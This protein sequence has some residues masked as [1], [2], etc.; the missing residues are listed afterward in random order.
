MVA[1]EVK[2]TVAHKSQNSDGGT[3]PHRSKKLWSEEGAVNR[4]IAS[5]LFLA[6]S[7][8]GPRC[9][10]YCGK[11]MAEWGNQSCR[12]LSR[13]PKREAPGNQEVGGV[14]RGR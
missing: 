13:G 4:R 5:L 12:F 2:S 9:R 7:S 11:D 10:H 1:A 6:A 3:F 14:H 8:F